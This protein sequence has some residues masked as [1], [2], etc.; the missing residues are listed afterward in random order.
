MMV[1]TVDG[2]LIDID[3]WFGLVGIIRLVCREID[4]ARDSLQDNSAIVVRQRAK[5]RS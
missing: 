5:R 2:K 1:V 4:I 3:K